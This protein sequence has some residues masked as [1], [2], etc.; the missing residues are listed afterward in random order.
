MQGPAMRIVASIMTVTIYCSTS[1]QAYIVCSPPD[2]YHS[3]EWRWQDRNKGQDSDANRWTTHTAGHRHH[4]GDSAVSNRA[5][6]W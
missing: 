5:K 2:G 1:F 3:T 6:A 4:H